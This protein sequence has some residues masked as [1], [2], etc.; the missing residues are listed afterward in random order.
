[1]GWAKWVPSATRVLHGR[2][3]RRVGV[4]GEHGAEAAVEVDVLGAVDVRDL[5]ALAVVDPD[6]PGRGVLPGRRH[7]AGQGAASFVHDRGR[8]RGAVQQG[9]FLLGDEAVDDGQFGFGCRRSRSSVSSCCREGHTAR[10]GTVAVGLGHELHE[11]GNGVLVR[12]E[13]PGT[14]APGRDA[15]WT[16]SQAAQSW[17]LVRSQKSTA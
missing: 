12:G 4:A 2:D 16:P 10:Q 17:R 9:R 15:R 11:L 1:M 7:A 8:G 6:G 5:G 13:R 3:D 14:V